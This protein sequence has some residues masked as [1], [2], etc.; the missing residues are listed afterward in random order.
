[1]VN[2]RQHINTNYLA[3]FLMS[4]LNLLFLHFQFKW[5]ID[6]EIPYYT[7]S[8]IDNFLACLLDVTV[9]LALFWLLTFRKL[10]VSLVLTFIITLTW[11]FCNVF[12]SR[13]FLQYL[14]WSSIGQARNLTEGIVIDSMWEG[15]RLIDIYYP[16]AVLL[17][18]WLFSRSKKKR[19]HH[20]E[21]AN[22]IIYMGTHPMLRTTG[23]F[24][25]LLPSLYR[26]CGRIA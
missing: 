4:V 5:T 13:F 25:L 26:F 19:Y 2:I 11:S 14:T 10:K 16:A 22:D 9:L 18:C 15:F 20:E 24:R 6:L 7:T 3:L 1:M 8:P 17:F 12:Y 21:S 23:T